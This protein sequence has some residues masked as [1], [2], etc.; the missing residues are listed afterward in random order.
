MLF[1]LPEQII[2][3]IRGTWFNF[4]RP[5][6]A[7]FSC[8]LCTCSYSFS[9]CDSCHLSFASCFSSHTSLWFILGSFFPGEV[10]Q[11]YFAILCGSVVNSVQINSHT[12]QAWKGNVGLY[13][14]C[15]IH[16]PSWQVS[17]KKQEVG[18]PLMQETY[19]PPLAKIY[20]FVLS[21]S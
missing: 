19:I 9:T 4:S 8:Y 2:N 14:S 6:L 16:A 5:A 12:R 3:V 18:Y 10:I 1:W 17:N 21:P 20:M 7:W 11:W 15:L 13:N